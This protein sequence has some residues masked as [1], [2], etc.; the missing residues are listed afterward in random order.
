[1]SDR[2]RGQVAGSAAQVYEDFFVPALFGEWAPRLA[3]AARIGPGDRVLDAGCGTG[4]LARHI[5]DQV[6]PSGSVVGIDINENM[7][8]VAARIAPGIEW[9]HGRAEALPFEEET[10]DAAVSQFAAMFFEDRVEAVREMVRV[11]RPGGC[12]AMAVWGPIGSA[13]GYADL[14]RILERMIGPEAGAALRAPFAMGDPEKLNDVF[15]EANVQQVEIR[16]EMGTARF[17]SIR[18]WMHT[19]IR[20][21]TLTEMI[22]D[23]QF[24]SLVRTAESELAGHTRSDGTVVF[25]M[26]ALVAVTQC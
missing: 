6:G 18:S 8:E 19:D 15:R 16:T 21:W 23:E 22:D 13:P 10:F 5:A 24:E 1:M 14:A 11:V 3:H 26:P 25:D 4:I 12:I 7:L 20:G 17:A 2:D 9:R